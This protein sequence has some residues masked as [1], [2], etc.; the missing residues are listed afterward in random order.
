MASNCYSAGKSGGMTKA[1]MGKKPNSTGVKVS[2]SAGKSS[3]TR[4]EGDK[5]GAPAMGKGK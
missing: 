3:G 1:S 5:S 2:A 4:R